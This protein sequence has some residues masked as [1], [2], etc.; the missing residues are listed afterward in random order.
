MGPLA[1]LNKFADD[2]NPGRLDKTL[3]FVKDAVFG[4]LMPRIGDSDKHCGAMLDL[5]FVADRFRHRGN[6]DK[7][8]VR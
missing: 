6:D 7:P 3:E 8:S 1:I 4:E 2:L 5:E